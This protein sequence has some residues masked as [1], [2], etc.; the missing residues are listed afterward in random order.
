MK[1]H[2][3]PDA[4]RPPKKPAFSALPPGT[5]GALP[6]ITILKP[7]EKPADDVKMMCSDCFEGATVADGTVVPGWNELLDN[8]V[9]TYRCPGCLP[10]KIAE[11]SARTEGWTKDDREKF[12][13]F[14]DRYKRPDLAAP[15]HAAPLAE[16]GE[17]AR[18]ILVKLG[19]R[20]LR[21]SVN[22]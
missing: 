3:G 5:P 22:P 15:M 16:A 17:L 19:S 12:C 18:A 9:T 1:F 10:R 11:S 13:Q 4:W 21:L 7:G 2:D 14:F 6:P 8:F 20:E